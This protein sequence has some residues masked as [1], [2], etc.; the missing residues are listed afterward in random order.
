MSESPEPVLAVLVTAPSESVAARLA[1]G[2]VESGLAACGNLVPGV[3]SIYAWNG[4]ICDDAEVLIV[5]KTTAAGFEALR[6]HLVGAHPYDTPEV[7]ALSVE[8]GHGPY[9]D[10]VRTMVGGSR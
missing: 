8:A 9:L 7:V 5:F 3:R 10:W 2:A 1:R 6:A 4:E